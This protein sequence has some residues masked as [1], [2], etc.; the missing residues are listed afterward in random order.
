MNEIKTAK[1]LISEIQSTLDAHN[2]EDVPVRC[3]VHYQQ[4]VRSLK[5]IEV[6]PIKFSDERPNEM[7]LVILTY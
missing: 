7:R 1:Q 4:N 5:A 3:Q 2:L 6:A